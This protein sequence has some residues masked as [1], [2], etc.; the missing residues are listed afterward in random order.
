LA[1]PFFAV[2]AWGRAANAE[3]ISDMAIIYLR[4]PEQSRVGQ[5]IGRAD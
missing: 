5:T 4:C 2:N 1:Q 3:Q